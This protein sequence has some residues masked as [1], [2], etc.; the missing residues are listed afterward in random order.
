MV[1]WE[2]GLHTG[3]VGEAEAEGDAREVRAASDGE[4]E[5][6]AVT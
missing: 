2:R 1:L 6:D 3:L 4:E 5:V